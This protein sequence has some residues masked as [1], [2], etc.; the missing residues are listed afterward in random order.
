MR[1]VTR[2]MALVTWLLGASACM[3]T[4]VQRV[5]TLGKGNSE[6]TFEPG[7]TLAGRPGEVVALPTFL[8][9]ARIGVT[10]R[11][12]LG[13]RAG[14]NAYEF[15]AKIGLTREDSKVQ[16]SLAPQLTPYF[17]A[18]GGGATGYVRVKVP[19]LLGFRLGERS[20]LV[21]GPAI[22]LY[23]GGAIADGSGARG[24]FIEPQTSL[25]LSLPIG[26]RVRIHPELGVVAPAWVTS[27]GRAPTFPRASF[28]LG[29]QLLR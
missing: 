21:L 22:H 2:S 3:T 1:R 11:V 4:P 14:S 25:G 26:D 6:V 12:D 19:V 17:L 7:A 13:I 29:F 9:A 23:T 15:Q 16:A 28:A 10:D 18:A 27:S 8:V 20:Q 24:L 5:E